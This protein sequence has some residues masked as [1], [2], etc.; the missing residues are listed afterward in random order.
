MDEALTHDKGGKLIVVEASKLYYGKNDKRPKFYCKYCKQIVSWAKGRDTAESKSYFK[1]HRNHPHK[2]GCDNIRK[3][4]DLNR[5]SE[6]SGI[7]NINFGVKVPKNALKEV[8][9]TRKSS[10]K[11]GVSSR[12]NVSSRGKDYI[13]NVDNLFEILD[14]I[15]ES[16]RSQEL[17]SKIRN[18]FYFPYFNH[19]RK[20]IINQHNSNTLK[21]F[22]FVTGTI[23]PNGFKELNEEQSPYLKMYPKES[24]G[25]VIHLLPI[26][27]Q[28][29]KTLKNTTFKARQDRVNKMYIGAQ[30]SF[31]S[32]Q[33]T[34]KG[35]VLKM[36]VYDVDEDRYKG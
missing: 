36:V 29:L 22:F 33:Q 14:E 32:Y 31:D 15:K 11:T 5:R 35:L 6:E 13:H 8:G 1:Q 7:D 4:L 17:M 23:K 10:Q 26:D 25:I 16:S 2:T 3:V 12:K 18:V 20:E 27:S 28:I 21:P 24:D 9:K 34:S 19:N 30:V